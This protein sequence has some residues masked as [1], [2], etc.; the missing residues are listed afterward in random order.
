LPVA[1]RRFLFLRFW[2]SSMSNSLALDFFF[3]FFF[4]I[5]QLAPAGCASS[6]EWSCRSCTDTSTPDV[7]RSW[8][9]GSHWWESARR[10]SLKTGRMR[11]R[12]ET[13]NRCH[14]RGSDQPREGERYEIG[15]VE[16]EVEL[17]GLLKHLGNVE[18]SIVQE[19][20]RGRSLPKRSFRKTAT[21]R[22]PNRKQWHRRSLP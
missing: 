21:H 2:F 22:C 11:S 6:A 9:T 8:P 10:Y 16:N 13:V 17:T 19:I 3:F 12:R 18:H 4:A 15:L 5:R 20:Q 7:V 1:C 14:H